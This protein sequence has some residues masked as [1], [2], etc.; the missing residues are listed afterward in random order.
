MNVSF[1]LGCS[2]SR[3]LHL[4]IDSEDFVYDSV[5]CLVKA[6]ATPC[7]HIAAAVDVS[8]NEARTQRLNHCS[9]CHP[10]V[11]GPRLAAIGFCALVQFNQIIN[12]HLNLP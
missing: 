4:G 5:S 7:H 6:Y 12:S 1:S 9:H 8:R 10:V 11:C 2:A 3:R